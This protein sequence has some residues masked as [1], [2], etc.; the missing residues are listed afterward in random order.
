MVVSLIIK[1]AFSAINKL[2]DQLNNKTIEISIKRSQFELTF[3]EYAIITGEDLALLS[4]VFG[5]SLDF[6]DIT[7]FN[8][9]LFVSYRGLEDSFM[10]DK[11]VSNIFKDIY[12]LIV[13]LRDKLCTC[14][15]LECILSPEYIKIFIDVPNIQL[16][17][18]NDVSDVLEQDPFLEF[19][20]DRPY[21][22]YVNEELN[23]E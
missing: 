5:D 8:D 12:K 14:P 16:S 6:T 9:R 19:G 3:E 20:A 13:V 7:C 1:N 22:L 23:N 17:N 11:N 15:A 21:L 4:I 2:N 18:I 10:E